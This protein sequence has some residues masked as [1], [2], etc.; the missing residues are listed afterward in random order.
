M[1]LEHQLLGRVLGIDQDPG[2]EGVPR[3]DR[4]APAGPVE[5][6]LHGLAAA[7]LPGAKL[8]VAHGVGPAPAAARARLAPGVSSVSST[9]SEEESEDGFESSEPVLPLTSDGGWSLP[10][11]EELSDSE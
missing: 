3:G 4:Q 8:P 9:T 11:A 6:V 1:E 10:D 2:E 7:L 5:E